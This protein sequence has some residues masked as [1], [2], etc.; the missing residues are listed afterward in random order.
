MP[1]ADDKDRISEELI[2]KLCVQPKEMTLRAPI[3]N[4]RFLSS[5]TKGR[6]VTLNFSSEY[7]D[8][9]AVEEVLTRTAI[10]NTLCSFVEVDGVYFMV[11]G[12]AFHD[13]DGEEPGIMNPDQFIYNSYTEMRNY[14]RVRLH[15]YFANEAGDKL[16]DAYRTVVYNSNMPLERIVLEQVIQGPNGSFA[17]PTVN[18]E[19]K[20]INVTTRDRRCYVNLNREFLTGQ[21]NVLAQTAIYSIVNSLCELPSIDSVQISVDGNTDAIFMESISL[22]GSFQMNKELVES[23]QEETAEE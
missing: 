5:E 11:E 3:S 10:V 19:T 18:S 21:Q 15:L 23:T 17:F 1:E 14:E 22:A 16:V 2:A 4:F 7:Y 9:S 12:E 6:I 20:V 8:L 13:A